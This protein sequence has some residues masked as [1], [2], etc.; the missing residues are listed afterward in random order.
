MSPRP[1]ILICT[2]DQL[3]PHAMGCY[4]D[5]FIK[6]PNLDRMA[7]EGV[8]FETAITNFPICMAARSVL[9]SGQYNRTCT[10]GVGNVSYPGGEGQCF[11][12]QYPDPGRPHLKDPTLA[13][14]LHDVGY[15]TATIGKWHIHSWPHDIG[16]DYYLIPRV[17]HAHTAQPF[18]ENGGPEFVPEGY[19]VD[20]EVEQV[21]KFLQGQRDSDRPFFLYYNI[22]PPHC[23]LADAPEK[24]LTMYDQ[25]EVPIRP[26]VN[27]D[28][29]LKNQEHWFRIYR[30]DYRY[31]NHHLPYTMEIPEGYDLK[32]LTAEYYGLVTWVDDTVGRMLNSLESNGL[33]ENTIVIFT[34]DH[35]DNLGSHGLVQKNS[36]NDESLCIPLLLRWPT[37]MDCSKVIKGQVGSLVDLMSTL[38]D[39]AGLQI[40][41]HIHGQSLAPLI[42]G[43]CQ[44]LERDY[45]IG[46]TTF[47]TVIRTPSH[48]YFLPYSGD[49]RELAEQPTQFYN[50]LKDPYQFNNLAGTDNESD[51]AKELDSILRE[52]DRTTPWMTDKTNRG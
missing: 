28:E 13:E 32:T 40:P 39:F 36:P 2:C 38:L 6:T 10:D 20:Y 45:S 46:E 30:W 7:G 24:Y 12:P 47:G 51:V 27:L 31:Y 22:S 37:G 43:D 50:S 44:R 41:N 42:N 52:W 29:P 25:A 49:S 14:A 16:F 26:N 4:G 21:D 34:S 1:N 19:S 11:F 3:R 33:A 8:R 15:H 35:G 9:M 17:N 5:E 18:T 48:T 23:P